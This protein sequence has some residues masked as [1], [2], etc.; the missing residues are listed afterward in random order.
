MRKFLVLFKTNIRRN[1]LV[2]FIS[3]LGAVV[4]CMGMDAFSGLSETYSHPFIGVCDY[5]KSELSQSLKHYLGDKI[6]Y[7]IE[8]SDNYNYL[9]KRLIKRKISVIIEIPKGFQEGA[10]TDVYK[11]LSITALNEYANMAFVKSYIDSYMSS[12]RTISTASDNNTETF[13]SLLKDTDNL[14]I[15]FE[16]TYIGDTSQKSMKSRAGFLSV[17][18]F[19]AFVMFG[20]GLASA[21]TIYEDRKRGT[22]SRIQLTTVK[23]W[24]YVAAAVA[25]GIA[26]QIV[27][28]V[29]FY[30][31]IAIRGYD[32]GV[33]ILAMA[34]VTTLYSLFTL[35]FCIFSAM[36]FNTRQGIITAVCVGG[37][38]FCI[39]GGCYFP[40]NTGSKVLQNISKFMPT[41]WYSAAYNNLAAGKS[42]AV[43][44]LV[45]V[46]SIMLFSMLGTYRFTKQNKVQ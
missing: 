19:V 16:R 25:T 5:D 14:S 30:G 34:L 18:G 28:I 4:L 2:L 40:V 6:G 39:L 15:P 38:L 13:L 8:E 41:Y 9:S 35:S 42:I 10:V 3:V 37:N 26:L 27:M 11:D 33:N 44:I 12:I 32:I 31:Y 1:I 23:S 17:N 43:D 20:F 29:L 7:N 46:L 45:L 21:I 36:A 22:Y 24:H